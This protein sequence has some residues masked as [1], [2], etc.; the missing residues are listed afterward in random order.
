MKCEFLI[1]TALEVGVP[2]SA[3]SGV[4]GSLPCRG[5]YPTG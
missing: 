1:R 2:T 5:R 3:G 4:P